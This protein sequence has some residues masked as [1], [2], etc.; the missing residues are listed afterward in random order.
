VLGRSVTSGRPRAEAGRSRSEAV[1]SCSAEMHS[2]ER[3]R[4][5]L[6]RDRAAWLERLA[7]GAREV[8]HLGCADSPYTD[9]LLS[10]GLLLHQRLTRVAS[11]T[12]IDVDARGLELLQ[13]ALPGERF[14]AADV[15]AA[16]PEQERGRYDL[17]IAG[18]VLEHV[19]NLD[20]FLRG[21]SALLAAGGR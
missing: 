2:G 3:L 12:G 15:A 20:A 7:A 8:A 14:V 9:E 4:M 18:E 10:A 1:R 6:V 11:V 13:R 17:V 16:V 19:P 5:P 21:C